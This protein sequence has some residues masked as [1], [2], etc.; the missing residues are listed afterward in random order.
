MLFEEEISARLPIIR[1]A[2]DELISNALN[3][4]THPQD[5]LLVITHSFYNKWL[6]TSI[7]KEYN[8][9]EFAF[10]PID[11]GRSEETHYEFISWYFNNHQVNRE[12]FLKEQKANS[13]IEQIEKLSINIEKT[14]YLKI[15]EADMVIKY[16]YQLSL[17]AQRKN[18]DWYFEIPINPRDGSKQE[19]IREHIINMLKTICPNF[20]TILRETY[21]PQL[22]NAIAHSQF[23]FGNRNIKYLNYSDNLKAHTNIN[24]LT[25]DQWSTYFHNTILLYKTLKE[26]LGTVKEMYYHKTKEN[27]HIE[28]R[29]TKSDG[30]E[31]FSKL[32]L[33]ND[34]MDWTSTKPK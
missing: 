1:E 26:G 20:S 9:S 33:R 34:F 15:W 6:P 27:G 21:V 31:V 11:F 25:F 16:F 19:I 30:K 12:N 24:T 22:R 32:Y 4:Q 8:L 2:I 14:I 29:I 3:Y 18:Y 28:T 23:L 5:V 7:Q 17:L 13:E 10:G